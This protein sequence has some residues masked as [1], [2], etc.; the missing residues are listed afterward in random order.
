[1][2]VDTDR[3]DG[4]HQS[5]RA[6][7]VLTLALGDDLFAL[8]LHIL[9]T[10]LHTHSG[11]VTVVQSI[12]FALA[13]LSNNPANVLKIVQLDGIQKILIVLILTVHQHEVPL[14]FDLIGGCCSGS[15][16]ASVR[17]QSTQISTLSVVIRAP[18]QSVSLNTYGC[19]TLLVLTQ[20][21]LNKKNIIQSGGVPGWEY[22]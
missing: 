22:C 1:M 18:P 13:N 8:L 10:H 4:T 16:A 21:E 12:C 3:T 11:V 7:I 2:M 15:G 6:P 14:M 9:N 17:N 20:E 5:V 19:R